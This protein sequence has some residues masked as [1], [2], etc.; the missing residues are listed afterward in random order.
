MFYSILKMPALKVGPLL[1]QENRG[2]HTNFTNLSSG[3]MLNLPEGTS[4]MRDN[5]VFQDGGMFLVQLDT[6]RSPTSREKYPWLQFVVASDLLVFLSANQHILSNTGIFNPEPV[7]DPHLPN[8]IFWYV[9]PAIY[10]LVFER[11]VRERHLT[12]EDALWEIC[13]MMSV[14][15]A[16]AVLE[17]KKA[18]SQYGFTIALRGE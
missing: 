16:N 17:V 9:G 12:G 2:W 18:L 7:A 4:L 10:R 3:F 8:M 15:I 11:L 6:L 14:Y 5:H 1:E 13:R